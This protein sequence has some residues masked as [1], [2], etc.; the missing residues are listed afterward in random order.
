MCDCFVFLPGFVML[1]FVVTHKV[2]VCF[3]LF[4]DV[5]VCCCHKVHD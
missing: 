2:R 5:I 3:D 1:L 4:G